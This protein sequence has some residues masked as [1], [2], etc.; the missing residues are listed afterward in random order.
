MLNL[1]ILYQNKKVKN[2][3]SVCIIFIIFV[4]IVIAFNIATSAIIVI[5]LHNEN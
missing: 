1:L 3:M 4:I 2:F 5:T